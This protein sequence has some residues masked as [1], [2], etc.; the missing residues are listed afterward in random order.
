MKQVEKLKIS[1][2]KQAFIAVCCSV[3][4]SDG[5]FDKDEVAIVKKCAKKLE[6]SS[7]GDWNI[8]Y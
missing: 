8:Y 1:R 3:G 5:N 7:S 6:S 4:A 2:Q